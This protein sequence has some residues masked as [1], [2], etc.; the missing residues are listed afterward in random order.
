MHTWSFNSTGGCIYVC[1]NTLEHM[2]APLPCI[3]Q[4]FETIMQSRLIEF[5]KVHKLCN[6]WISFIITITLGN[7]RNLTEYVKARYKAELMGPGLTNRLKQKF[8]SLNTCT[9][10]SNCSQFITVSQIKIQ[11]FQQTGNFWLYN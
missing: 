2:H 6:F 7:N 9:K 8:P 10:S 4:T 3:Y 11:L 1:I 5:C